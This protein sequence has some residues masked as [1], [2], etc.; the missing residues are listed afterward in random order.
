MKLLLFK[1]LMMLFCV[2][3]T[4]W[5]LLM[6]DIDYLSQTAELHLALC[7]IVNLFLYI[8]FIGAMFHK[9]FNG[10]HQWCC[11]PN[12]FRSLLYSPC[13]YDG[14]I[15][16]MSLCVCVKVC[17]SVLLS[18]ITPLQVQGFSHSPGSVVLFFFF[19]C[20]CVCMC[21]F[22]CVQCYLHNCKHSTPLT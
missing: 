9:A 14:A 20:M 11:N 5:C 1:E 2:P 17:V 4:Q 13:Q 21:V 22:V 18:I 15:V 12:P 16:I 8:L 7:S 10:N 19:L 6:M 3:N